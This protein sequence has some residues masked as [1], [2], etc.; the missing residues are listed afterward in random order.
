MKA[1]RSFIWRAGILFSFIALVA[2]MSVSRPDLLTG[3]T[4][5]SAIMGPDL[6]AVLVVVLTITFASVANIHLSVSR[7]IATAPDREK[8][9][10]ASVRVRGQI[11]SNAWLIFWAFLAALV[12]LFI[13]GQFPKEAM[14]RSF[15]IGVCLTVVLLNG[16]VMHDLYRSIFILAMSA[17]ASEANGPQSASPDECT[18][19]E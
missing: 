15:S 14:V 9:Q 11:S 3:N 1:S 5:L 2:S 12:A 16:L 10:A 4:F 17:P 8:V 6:V 13:Y 7:M 19:V 18:P